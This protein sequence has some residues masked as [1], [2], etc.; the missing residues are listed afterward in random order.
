MRK[1]RPAPE[2][3]RDRINLRLTPELFVA[4]DECRRRRAGAVS[5]NTWIAEAINEKLEREAAPSEAAARGAA[6]A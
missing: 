6:H 5:R 2:P 3:S 1:T 4:I